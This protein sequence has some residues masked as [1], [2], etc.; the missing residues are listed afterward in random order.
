MLAENEPSSELRR[1][2]YTYVFSV[3]L[4]QKKVS[5]DPFLR[6][7]FSEKSNQRSEE[8]FVTQRTFELQSWTTSY[9]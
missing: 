9:F 4:W 2:T 3:N 5:K 7:E 8:K 1:N 6:R